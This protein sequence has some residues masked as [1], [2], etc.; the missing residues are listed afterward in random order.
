MENLADSY[1]ATQ[2]WGFYTVQL[3]EKDTWLKKVRIGFHE[4]LSCINF[5]FTSNPEFLSSS[6][7]LF[8]RVA[9]MSPVESRTELSWAQ[10]SAHSPN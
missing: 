5:S 7:V 2:T 10:K 6:T 3:I 1:P 9:I 8:V 4:A